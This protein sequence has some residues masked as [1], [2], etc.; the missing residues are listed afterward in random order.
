MRSVSS[1]LVDTRGVQLR[2]VLQGQDPLFSGGDLDEAIQERKR[3]LKNDVQRVD[4]ERLL[5]LDTD[6]WA[7]E[8]AATYR[9]EPVVLLVSA[10]TYDEGP[11]VHVDVRHEHD[12]AVRDPSKPAWVPAYSMTLCVPFTGDKSLLELRGYPALQ[13]PPPAH[14]AEGELRHVVVFAHDREP[15]L[16]A[17]ADTF[18]GHINV[19]LGGQVGILAHFNGE[20]E[21]FAAACIEFRKARA[22]EQRERL[23]SIGIPVRRRT[24][25][26]RVFRA[27]GVERRPAPVAPARRDPGVPQP[28]EPVLVAE[29]YEHILS[30][31]TAMARGMERQPGD[32]AAW[33]EEQ[34]RDA[35]L[36]I[37]NTHYQGTATGETFQKSGKTDLLVRVED[38]NVFVGECKWWSGEQAFGGA[39]VS[40]QP[41]ALDQLLSYSTWRDAR[42]ALVVF[43]GRKDMTRV[44]ERA[45]ATLEAHTSFR[46]WEPAREEDDGVLHCRVALDGDRQAALAAVFVHLPRD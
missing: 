32:Y 21:R 42:L 36:V 1:L 43:V 10:M 34:L 35:L 5:T 24:D 25:A 9:A 16:K 19:A 8:L 33:Q 11:D 45:R 7:R 13:S 28:L 30:V 4:V 12:R 39:L 44:V 22:L 27:P 6:T 41:S 20:L 37:L 29:F 31:I 23:D 18:V 14:I 40:S 3:S 2:A 15:D 17:V 26:P 46:A 38:R